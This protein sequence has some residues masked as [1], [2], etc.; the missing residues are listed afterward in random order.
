[1]LRPLRTLY[2][3]LALSLVV[4]L[5]LAGL[6]YALLSQALLER[7][8][9]S[10]N[11]QLNRSLAADLAREMDLVKDGAVDQSTMHDAFHLTM[12]LNPSIEIY[13]LDPS[14][15]ILDFSAEPNAIRRQS[16]DLGP[17]REFL[18]GDSMYPL[19]GD[20]PRDPDQQ[21]S[22]SVAVLPHAEKPEGYLYV[23]L[24]SSRLDEA[25]RLE[26]T[27]ALM[28][29]S[30]WALL[31][32]LAL[33]LPIGLVLFFY[34]TRRIRRL[35]KAV[36]QFQKNG[37][38]RQDDSLSLLSRPQVFHDEISQLANRFGIMAEHIRA[39][40]LAQEQQDRQ[41]RSMVANV[42]HDLRT[43]LAALHGYIERLH[44]H[45]ES[46]PDVERK[47]YLAIAL[48]N[49]QRL[50]RLI[51]DLFELSKLEAKDITPAFEPFSLAELA[52]D[53]V[54]KF[55]LQAE[56]R[57]I[58][59]HCRSNNPLPMV[60]GDIALMDRALSNLID[61]AIE[62]SHQGGQVILQLD[63][64]DDAVNV[65]IE[66]NGKGISHENI[67]AIFERFYRE[68]DAD[69]GSRAHAGLGLAITHRILELHE[70]SITVESQPEQGTTF[71]FRMP[72]WHA[73]SGTA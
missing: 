29:L 60:R 1:M 17:I 27:G 55:R 71:Q 65:S 33:G 37:Y 24:Q 19:M 61:N 44:S 26:Q 20:D 5:F 8:H 32:S 57:G 45:Y 21:K 59:L 4:L 40:Y 67:Q 53:V 25:Y 10:G 47:G 15:N 54:L 73:A 28:S 58:A 14:G 18:A 42:S 68:D 50:S 48:R 63:V 64:I 62:H 41:R 51:D 35:D 11:Q 2:S 56:A 49:S 30:L 69:R 31:G 13:Y 36:Y 9:Q 52:Q 6:F 3:K 12:L 16:V 66:D 43:P 34:L 23:V 70:Q 46:L 7:T 39:Q 38:K 72:I 22:F